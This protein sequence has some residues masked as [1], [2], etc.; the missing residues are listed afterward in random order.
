MTAP[1]ARSNGK[2]KS[3]GA[4]ELPP[5]PHG[6]SV[7]PSHGV[8]EELPPGWRQWPAIGQVAAQLGETAGAIR[9]LVATGRLAPGRMFPDHTV[10]YDPAIVQAY[11]ETRLEE[12]R[13]QQEMVTAA[14]MMRLCLATAEQARNDAR[15]MFK[16]FHDPVL[17]A[18]KQS[19]QQNEK[20]HEVTASLRKEIDAG[21]AAQRELQN[22]VWARDM[23][24]REYSDKRET[25]GK[26]MSWLARAFA[27]K[28]GVSMEALKREAQSANPDV[29]SAVADMVT[30]APPADK[31]APT[32]KRLFA[33]LTPEQ[34]EQLFPILKPDQI[35]LVIELGR[36]AG[37]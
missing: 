36:E 31:P 7:S 35:D 13:E 23:A 20:L 11:A 8:P 15:E 29:A 5:P 22:D 2:G 30:P 6:V 10:R 27:A 28:F 4:A 18:L 1:R 25:R 16:L 24:T 37:E 19:M 32:W 34:Q 12:R 21:Q 33:S 3:N 14:E 26:A 17:Q 9:N